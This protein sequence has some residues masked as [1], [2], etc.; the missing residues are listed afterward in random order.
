M[1]T[2]LILF[3]TGLTPFSSNTK[4]IYVKEWNDWINELRA[5]D[6]FQSCSFFKEGGA[7]ISGKNKELPFY[8]PHKDILRGIAI[9]KAEN[10]KEA[11]EIVK[12]CPVFKRNGEIQIKEI[13]TEYL[14]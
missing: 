10:L 12:Q 5:S 11:T 2:F 8:V 1:K 3:K 4:E 13:D 14:M 9:I 7:V 6:K